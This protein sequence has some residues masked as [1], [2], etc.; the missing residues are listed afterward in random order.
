MS[1]QPPK[2]EHEARSKGERIKGQ[3]KNYSAYMRERSYYSQPTWATARD[4][5]SEMRGRAKRGFCRNQLLP[6]S[7]SVVS[8]LQ[9]ATNKTKRNK[10][11]HSEGTATI[12]P[13]WRECL[14][15]S[16]MKLSFEV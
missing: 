11:K 10:G 2:A 9:P 1:A 8:D 3:N 16:K 7:G 5:V 15:Y 14:A 6:H 13:F 4:C 12:K